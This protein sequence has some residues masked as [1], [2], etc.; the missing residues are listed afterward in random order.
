MEEIEGD[1]NAYKR[2]FVSYD[3]D[4]VRR[5]KAEYEEL[6]RDQEQNTD[7]QKEASTG[8]YTYKLARKAETDEWVVKAYK[9]GKYD[10]GA[11]YYTND[12]QDAIDTMRWLQSHPG[13]L[14]IGDTFSTAHEQN[15]KVVTLPNEEGEF[16]GTDSDGVKCSFNTKMI[17]D[18]IK[19]PPV[20]DPNVSDEDR[21][22]YQQEIDPMEDNNMN[23][24]KTVTEAILQQI[25]QSPQIGFWYEFKTPLYEYRSTTKSKVIALPA[26]SLTGRLFENKGDKFIRIENELDEAT[27]IRFGMCKV[28]NNN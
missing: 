26:R 4:H 28:V 27:C 22:N 3:S 23:N 7:I 20:N 5:L 14:E 18:V 24:F 25:D 12:K 19:P 16:I 21:Y 13:N 8:N 15:C 6:K 11:T 10:E 9:D 2:Q 1:L 17:T